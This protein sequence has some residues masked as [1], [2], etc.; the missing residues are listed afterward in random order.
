MIEKTTK[1]SSQLANVPAAAAARQ[2]LVETPCLYGGRLEHTQLGSAATNDLLQALNSQACGMLFDGTLLC[3]TANENRLALNFDTKNRRIEVQMPGP[4][5][6]VVDASGGN[7]WQLRDGFANGSERR[8]HN[9]CGAL[10]WVETKFGF[11]CDVRQELGA[12]TR[13]KPAKLPAR[14]WRLS[15]QRRP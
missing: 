2:R 15:I 9:A 8:G 5:Q 3:D 13:S 1:L 12:P 6:G 10:T 4:Y 7:R 11:M 14:A